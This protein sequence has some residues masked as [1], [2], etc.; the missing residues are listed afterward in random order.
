MKITFAE[1][2][3]NKFKLN[4]VYFMNCNENKNTSSFNKSINVGVS[5][6]TCTNRPNYMNNIF[7]NFNRQLYKAKELIIILNKNI[8]DINK[9][10]LKASSFQNISVYQLDENI[11]LGQCLNFAVNKCKHEIIAKFDDDDYYSPYYL[12]S[13]IIALLKTNADIVGKSTTFVYFEASKILAIRNP[14]KENRYLTRIEGPTMII[15]KDVF[16]KIKFRN[17]T[18]GEDV[19]FCKDCIKKGFKIY[20]HDKY[21][22]VYIRHGKTSTHTWKITDEYFK[23]L[24]I[25][26]G[27]VEDYKSYIEK[28]E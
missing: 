2:S 3:Y 4:G 18:L 12:N 22:Y 10:K 19:N 25:K 14:R 13:S 9:W 21:N 23:K 27:K 11:S 20:S 26:I 5:V 24:C 1:I 16:K 28:I 8:M 6:I 17:I 7:E 15:K